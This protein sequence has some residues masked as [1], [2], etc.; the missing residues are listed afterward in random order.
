MAALSEKL[1]SALDEIQPAPSPDTINSN[2]DFQKDSLNE[3]ARLL[4]GTPDEV[5]EAEEYG[6]TLSLEETKMVS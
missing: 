6:K 5:L 1:S 4:G 2:P 3:K